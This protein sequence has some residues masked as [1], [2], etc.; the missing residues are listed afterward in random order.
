MFNA[1]MTCKELNMINLNKFLK[2]FKPYRVSF[3]DAD[4]WTA[5]HRAWTRTEALEWAA[6]YSQGTCTITT[7]TGRFVASITR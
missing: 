6:C 4:G 1:Q 5:S 7:R 2:P 3:L